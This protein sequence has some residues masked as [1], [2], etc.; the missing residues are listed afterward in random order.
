VLPKCI[1]DIFDKVIG[2]YEETAL[3][4]ANRLKREGI[5]SKK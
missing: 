4:R 1:D 3:D 2:H 5:K